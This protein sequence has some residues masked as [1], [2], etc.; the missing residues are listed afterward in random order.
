[1]CP[2]FPYWATEVIISEKGMFIALRFF[3]YRD[4]V[5]AYMKS[6]HYS[7]Q[8]LLKSI[9]FTILYIT[10]INLKRNSTAVLLVVN[11][12]SKKMT[13]ITLTGIQLHGL[14]TLFGV[15]LN[16]NTIIFQWLPLPGT[17]GPFLVGC[18][19]KAMSFTPFFTLS[20]LSQP[21]GW[22]CFGG[23]LSDQILAALVYVTSW[24]LRK[25]RG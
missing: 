17:Q 7:D 22:K 3:F 14:I 16:H 4:C 24:R 20:R 12:T 13:L 25:N 11:L 5:I 8:Y 18:L 1:M 21:W 10:G 2:T 9:F 6:N 15:I 23:G 19:R